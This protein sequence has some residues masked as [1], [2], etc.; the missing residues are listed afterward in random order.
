MYINEVK[1]LNKD[2]KGKFPYLITFLLLPGSNITLCLHT[3][4][5]PQKDWAAKKTGIVKAKECLIK[6]EL[7]A[8]LDAERL[9]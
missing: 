1:S 2:S 9:P 4:S 3:T 6:Y 8:R 7:K 5:Q